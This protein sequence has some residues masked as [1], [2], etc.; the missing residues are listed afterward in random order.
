MGI[1][2]I[3]DIDEAMEARLR[4]RA[5]RHGTS[6]EEEAR[7]ILRAAL[8][9]ETSTPRDLGRA[10]HERF[11]ALGGVDLPTMPREPLRF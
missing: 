8:E 10:I 9:A 4:S 7:T 1:L 6:M 5:A 3:P 2:T 11:S